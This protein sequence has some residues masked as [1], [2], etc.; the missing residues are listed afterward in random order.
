M[1]V[2]A[3]GKRSAGAVAVEM[4]DRRGMSPGDFVGAN[5][6]NSGDLLPLGGTGRPA[7]ERDCSNAADVEATAFGEHFHGDRLFATKISDGAGHE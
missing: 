1:R 4:L 2:N 6:E 5:G 7:A 3:P